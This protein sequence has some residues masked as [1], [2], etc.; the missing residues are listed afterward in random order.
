M[1]TK[2]FIDPQFDLFIHSITD[3]PL[4]D[5]RETMERP[6]FSLSKRKR[7][8]AIN[9]ESTDGTI[10]VK[11]QPHQDFGMAT[12]WDADILIWA[13]SVIIDMQNRGLNDIPRTLHF[14]PYDLLR[15]INRDTGGA[16]YE[17]LKGALA[18]LQATIIRTNIRARGK[19][20]F[21]QFS[22]LESW[23]DLV[24]EAT[25][26]SRGMSLTLSEWLYEGILMKGGVLAISPEYFTI[27]GGRERWLYRVARKHAGGHTGEGFSIPL[28]TLYTKSG[29]EGTY[30]KF[31]FAIKRIAEADALPEFHLQ[32]EESVG[33]EPALRM[34]RRDCL[35]LDHSGY[36]FPKRRLR[37][38]A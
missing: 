7:L 14:H 18:R 2:R 3:L 32:W 23:E 12:I 19:K 17:L 28:P 27:T 26:Q 29:A 35:S 4:R 22:W 38:V 1:S 5:Q 9:Y 34:I 15:A 31:K 6:F 11:V 24:D 33:E 8:A 13:V 21:R 37:H 36:A 10:W 30:R 16:D 25:G 20:K